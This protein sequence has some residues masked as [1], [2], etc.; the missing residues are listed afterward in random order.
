MVRKRPAPKMKNLRTFTTLE[1]FVLLF[2][3]FLSGG[4]ALISEVVW[5]RY[6]AILLGHQAWA[7]AV[8]LAILLGGMCVGY[9]IFGRLSN[10]IIRRPFLWCG[11][12]ELLL[13]LWAIAF[14]SL[15]HI[16][17]HHIGTLFSKWGLGNNLVDVFLS[18]SLIGIPSLLFGAT[19]PL[20]TQ[21]A[22][23][24]VK[25]LSTFHTQIYGWNTV[26]GAIGAFLCGYVV[27][28]LFS[29]RSGLMAVSIANTIAG[30]AL[31]SFFGPLRSCEPAVTAVEQ[32]DKGRW[33]RAPFFLLSFVCGFCVLTM[34]SFLIRL[35]GLSMGSS[36]YSFSLVLSIFVLA[37]GV[38]ALAAKKS[39]DWVARHLE[40]IVLGEA[41]AFALL[42]ITVDYWSY[43]VHLIRV[44]LKDHLAAF[45]LFHLLLA[46]AFGA[47]FFIPV[48][49]AG[50]ILPATFHRVLNTKDGVGHLVGQV[51]GIN[52]CGTILGAFTGGYVLLL[53]WNIDELW[54]ASLI[55]LVVAAFLL[56]LT[57]LVLFRRLNLS[58]R[59]GIGIGTLLLVGIWALPGF[60]YENFIQAFRRQAVDEHTFAGHKSFRRGLT[61][62][63]THLFWKDGPTD[64]VA[65]SRSP[66]E[67]AE[68][69]RSLFVNG[70]SDGNTLGD[71]VTVLLLGHVPA[72]LAERLDPVCVVGLGTGMTAAAL[73]TYSETEQIDIVEISETVLASLPFFDKYNNNV[74]DSP[75]VKFFLMDAMRYLQ[76]APNKYGLIVS[77]PSN[78]WT[79]G[80]ENLYT[81]DFY[82]IAAKSL[83]EKGI[84]A[85][86]IHTY[87]FNDSLFR[88][89]LKAMSSQFKFVHVFQLKG[90]DFLL[91]GAN[92][93][94]NG[95]TFTRM[96]ARMQEKA[97]AGN[98]AYLGIRD[99]E[100]ILATELMT[101]A[102]SREL[103]KGQPLHRLEAPLLGSRAVQAFF[104]GNFAEIHKL[105]RSAKLYGNEIENSLLVSSLKG[106]YLDQ[107]MRSTLQ[108]AFCENPGTRNTILCEEVLFAAHYDNPG[109]KGASGYMEKVSSR[110]I[111]SLEKIKA[112]PRGKF[113]ASDLIE[114][115]DLFEAYKKYRSPLSRVPASLF[116]KKLDYCLDTVNAK[117]DLYGE[118]LLQKVL[119]IDNFVSEK[120]QFETTARRFFAWFEKL[121]KDNDKY[122][123][124]K[125]AAELLREMVPD[126]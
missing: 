76:G 7:T 106:R 43:G 5:Q 38:G 64:S 51:Y 3:L 13:A 96:R 85:Q 31:L 95:E 123:R 121:P 107:E 93:P 6:L 103:A 52:T 21:G 16:A 77:E 53:W 42:Y 108:K 59:V 71:A 57:P 27:I 114:V 50:M 35:V 91:L 65:I 9:L 37:L 28:P 48:A 4:A 39:I 34:E 87:S 75:K 32:N 126:E 110:V 56:W 58:S 23:E 109:D 12:L 117:T 111:A 11:I 125:N 20:I 122:G 83:R 70:K 92:H 78:P 119:V 2:S 88:M 60:Q 63:G 98:L 94:F 19:L 118:C 73:A 66:V 1:R 10:K 47:L 84:F 15:F 40:W 97:V 86:W 18:L 82:K 33:M 101:P 30:V 25:D 8:V 45:Y 100:V 74:K 115:F 81:E 68:A 17:F 120:P 112:P 36:H 55:A 90:T 124:F 49:L 72:L 26:G 89:I 105:K 67:G 44:M 54:K 14:P 29:L 46:V 62:S 22:Q 113:V 99:P 79:G 102:V 104:G 61:S 69:S 80:V 24:R 116:L 41:I